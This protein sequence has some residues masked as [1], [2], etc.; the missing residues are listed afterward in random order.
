MVWV[1]VT[2]ATATWIAILWAV[3]AAG[4][5]APRRASVPAGEREDTGEPRALPA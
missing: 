2:L 4:R 1:H 3:A 5:L